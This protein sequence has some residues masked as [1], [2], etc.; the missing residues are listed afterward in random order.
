MDKTYIQGQ[1]DAIQMIGNLCGTHDCNS[2]TV[3]Q[4][5][6]ESMACFEFMRQYPNKALSLMLQESQKEYTYYTEYNVRFP[7]CNLSIDDLA[8]V[9][10]CKA[11]FSGDTSCEGGDCVECWN[12][13]FCGDV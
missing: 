5:I 3:G 8:D 13:P 6:G 4:V 10:C 2:C 7:R 1:T 9:A 11:V 12:R